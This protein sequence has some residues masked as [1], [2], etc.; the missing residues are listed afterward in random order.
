MVKKTFL[1]NTITSWDEPHRARHQLT[2]SLAKKNNVIFVARNE[3]GSKRIEIQEISDSI[4]LVKPYFPL[5]YRYRYRL[6]IINEKYQNWLFKILK[7]QYP[8]VIVINFDFTAHRI[9]SF[10]N[11]VIYYC[12]DEYI[13]NSQYPNWFINQYHRVCEQKVIKNSIFNVSTSPYLTR[14][15]KLHNQNTYEILLGSTPVELPVGYSGLSNHHQ[16]KII[17]GLLGVI[18]KKQISIN[19]INELIEDQ[20]LELVLIGPVDKSFINSI[21]CMSRVRFTG[22]LH[23]QVL[24]QEL[25]NIDVGLALY[26]VKGINPGTTPNKLWQYLSVGKPVVI[27]DIPNLRPELFPK[28][29]IYVYNGKKSISYLIHSAYSNNTVDLAKER[30]QFSKMNTWDNRVEEFLSLVKNFFR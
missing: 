28:D 10:F 17:V 2:L 15:M 29:S 8:D 14:K 3:L 23:G 20:D 5:D 26:N 13:G 9:F 1:V 19:Q 27:N 4:T 21:S 7:E 25:M 11:S 18:G 22:L 6:P 30:I 12:N 16:K 24:Q